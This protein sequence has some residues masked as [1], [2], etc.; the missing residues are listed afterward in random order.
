MKYTVVGDHGQDV[1]TGRYL[2]RGTEFDDKDV[3]DELKD[4]LKWLV[5]N[6]LVVKSADLPKEADQPQKSEDIKQEEV[7]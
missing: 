7:T 4:H 1:G 3:P 6:E 5:D 2:E